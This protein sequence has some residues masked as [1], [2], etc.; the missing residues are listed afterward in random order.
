MRKIKYPD[1]RPRIELVDAIRGFALL[2]ILLL[3]AIEHFDFLRHAEMNPKIFDSVDPKVDHIIRF[4]F[5]GKAYTIFSIMFGLSFFIQM[6]RQEMKGIDFR[7]KFLW[8]LTIL[9]VMGYIHSFFYTGDVLAVYALFGI[10]LVFLYKLKKKGLIWIAILLVIQIPMLYN[11]IFSFYNPGFEIDRGIMGRLWGE[12][13]YTY[14]NGTFC[15]VISFNL[16]KGQM[17]IWSW[18]Y[19]Y[20]RYLQLPGLF[21]CGLLLGRVRYFENI[22]K[23]KNVTLKVLLF[24]IIIFGLL[25]LLILLLPKFELTETQRWLS[26]TLLSSYSGLVFTAALICSFVLIFYAAK[27]RVKNNLLAA[28][29][30]MSLTNYVMQ[31]LIGIPFFYGFGLSMYK[32]FGPTLSVIYGVLYFILQIIFCKIWIKHFYYGPLEWIW[33]ALTYLDFRIKFR[34]T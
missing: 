5:V 32:Y 11:L 21:I 23:Y 12:A 28:Y 29:G 14:E 34:K 15:E 2:G 10:P 27:S 9:F 20:G 6:D 24:S 1:R 26:E 19:F 33:R 8:R 16:W 13:F 17:A 3:H 25:Y 4:L 31:G 18:M 7:W 30:R 22:E